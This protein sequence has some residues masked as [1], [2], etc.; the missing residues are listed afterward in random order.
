MLDY[1]DLIA[2]LE[3][4]PVSEVNRSIAQSN[5]I[6]AEAS[7]SPT[8]RILAWMSGRAGKWGRALRAMLLPTPS[9]SS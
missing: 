6:A 9:Q 3:K 4:L 1:A 7:I 5:F 8:T 2:R